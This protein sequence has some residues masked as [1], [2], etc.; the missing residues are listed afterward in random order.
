M[1]ARVLCWSDDF[2]GEDVPPGLMA[3]AHP[4]VRGRAAMARPTAGTTGGHVAAIY[5][6][7]GEDRAD[8][9]FQSL[10]DNEIRVLGGNAVVAD[11]T[12]RGTIW[13]GLTDNDDV[14]ASLR[15]GGRLRQILPDQETYGTLVIP[16]TVGLVKGARN[17]DAARQLIDYLLS[18]DVERML[19]DFGFTG[20]SVRQTE[21]EHGVRPMQIDYAEAARIMPAAIR[22]S[23]AILEGR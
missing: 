1:R 5:V 19:I 4:A 7:W 3:L 2:A 15:E 16:C 9:Y 14:A 23:I 21:G 17:P 8:A 20:F 13:I 6:L 11:Q 10:R 18:E 22:R 12:G